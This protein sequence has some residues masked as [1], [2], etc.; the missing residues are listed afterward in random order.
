MN[1][2]GGDGVHLLYSLAR[3]SLGLGLP[4]RSLSGGQKNHSNYFRQMPEAGHHAQALNY[5]SHHV[6][7]TQS[8]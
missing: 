4:A 3:L 5:I 6:F 7:N 8:L 2:G 1:L